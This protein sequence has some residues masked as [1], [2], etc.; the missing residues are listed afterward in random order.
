MADFRERSR[1]VLVKAAQDR[2]SRIR[3][4]SD[5]NAARGGPLRDASVPH[6]HAI[7]AAR[8]VTD[9]F[10]TMA[11]KNSSRQPLGDAVRQRSQPLTKGTQYPSSRIAG[12][13]CCT[14]P[15]SRP[16]DAAEH[17]AGAALE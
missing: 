13:G 7:A 6:L 9:R 5:D 4:Q 16:D 12:G 15:K 8:C 1:D 14:M 10:D 2:G 17:R 11:E 3:G